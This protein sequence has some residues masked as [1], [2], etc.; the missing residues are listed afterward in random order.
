MNSVNFKTKTADYED[1]LKHLKECS[2]SFSPPL[3]SYVKLEEYSLKISKHAVTFE[4]WDN[5]LLVGLIAVYFNNFKTKTGYI[6]NVSVTSE[7]F[8]QGIAKKLLGRVMDHGRSLGF[9]RVK[10]EVNSDNISALKLYSENKFS[11]IGQDSRKLL[12]EK[13]L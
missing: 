6:T 1:I 4:A 9:F 7:Y 3:K 12:M 8:G 11:V 10:L 5:N 13:T 2:D